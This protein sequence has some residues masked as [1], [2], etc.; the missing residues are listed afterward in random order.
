[1]RVLP[2]PRRYGDGTIVRP[3][4][5]PSRLECTLRPGRGGV[6]IVAAVTAG[7]VAL[8]DAADRDGAVGATSTLCVVRGDAPTPF[9]IEVALPAGQTSDLDLYERPDPECAAKIAP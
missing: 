1:V 2:A 3:S 8:R 7:T 4:A 5:L 9:T 6:R